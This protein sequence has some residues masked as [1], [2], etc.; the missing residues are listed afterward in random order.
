MLDTRTTEQ[1]GVVVAANLCDATSNR[2]A[3]FSQKR[4]DIEA[5]DALA[6]TR[7]EV[8]SMRADL[9]QL[10]PIRNAINENELLSDHLSPVIDPVSDRTRDKLS[11]GPQFVYDLS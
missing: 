5:I 2:F 10:G 7:A 4:L 6:T 1:P 8:A 11:N 3:V 9:S